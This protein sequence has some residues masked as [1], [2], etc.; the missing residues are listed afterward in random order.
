MGRP[1]MPAKLLLLHGRGEGKDSAGRPVAPPPKFKREAPEPPEWLST[2][3]RE[4]WER[5]APGL[6]RLD[7]LKPE[8]R[9][10]L[11]AYCETWDTY[12]TAVLKVRADGM[13]IVNPETGLERQSP[14]VK[15]M[16]EAGRDLLRYAREFG[17]TP[18]AERAI[19]SAASSDE[20]DENP[21]AS[22]Q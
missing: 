17:L 22:G 19:S 21:F 18:A 9:A 16:Q 1:A 20:D 5:V 7:L 14:V 4:E 8:D 15:I 10:I 2:E 6:Q 11:V 13:T 3:A 12:M